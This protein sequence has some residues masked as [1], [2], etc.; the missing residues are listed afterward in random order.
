MLIAYNVTTFPSMRLI[1]GN[2]ICENNC[3]ILN[4]LSFEARI[5]RGV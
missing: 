2:F 4:D 5:N 3:M 1:K